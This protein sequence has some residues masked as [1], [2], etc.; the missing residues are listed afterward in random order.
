MP[1]LN[2]EYVIENNHN[3][4]DVKCVV[5]INNL[6][7]IDTKVSAER[8][9]EYLKELQHSMKLE[10]EAQDLTGIELGDDLGY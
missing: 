1:P 9:L 10:V 6:L 5:E 7:G 2:V 3:Y 4:G 8:M